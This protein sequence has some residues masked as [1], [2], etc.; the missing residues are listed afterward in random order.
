MFFDCGA[1]YTSDNRLLCN[2][3]RNV[4]GEVIKENTRVSEV[5]LGFQYEDAETASRKHDQGCHA[6]PVIVHQE[7]PYRR[8]HEVSQVKRRGPHAW[9]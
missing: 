8:T 7:A 6:E 1:N 3:G 4:H 2:G 5:L 9:N